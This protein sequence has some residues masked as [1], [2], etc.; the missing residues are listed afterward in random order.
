MTYPMTSWSAS[1]TMPGRRLF[2][3]GVRTTSSSR[4]TRVA[5]SSKKP[6]VGNA[7][8]DYAARRCGRV[9]PY[10]H[11]QHVGLG[12]LYGPDPPPAVLRRVPALKP[13]AKEELLSAPRRD[14]GPDGSLAVLRRLLAIE[15]PAKEELLPAPH[16]GRALLVGRG[17]VGCGASSS[18]APPPAPSADG[19]LWPALD[20]ASLPPALP[21]SDVDRFNRY[22]AD[23]QVVVSDR[24]VYEDAPPPSSLAPLA[25]DVDFESFA[26]V[27]PSQEQPLTTN[28]V[29]TI[30][31]GTSRP[32]EMPPRTYT[33]QAVVETKDPTDP[34]RYCVDSAAAAASSSSPVSTPS[35]AVPV[36]RRL[37][38]TRPRH[39]H[40]V[41]RPLR[42]AGL[43]GR[44][45][46]CG[47]RIFIRGSSA[48]PVRRRRRLARPRHRFLA[49]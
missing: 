46:G 9:G 16:R 49:A 48:S 13:P 37:R 43:V 7:E 19:D 32:F 36:R 17:L 41:A 3:L 29:H 35:P 10:V 20:I 44:L 33:A 12:L 28:V 6:R 47:G 18:A 25:S 8:R 39:R 5:P 30:D 1:P 26:P 14:E 15:P 38:P 23:Q 22:F 31:T 45:L 34:P 42:L 21:D 11:F 24:P 40:L 4:P 2:I 27:R